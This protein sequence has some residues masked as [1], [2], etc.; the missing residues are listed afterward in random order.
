M[1]ED[2]ISQW[3][4]EL[5]HG[6]PEAARRIW[7]RYFPRL[8]R[9]TRD[10]LSPASRRAQDEEDLAL[11]AINAL[12][13][14]AVEG[15]FQQLSNRDDLWQI[16]VMIATRKAANV[17]RHQA[18]RRESGECDMR[19]EGGAAWSLDLLSD[20]PASHAFLNTI[21]IHCEELLSK[22]NGKLREVAILKLQ[23]YSNEEI[24]NLRQ[25]GLSTIER[26]LKMIREI[27]QDIDY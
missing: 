21:D 5:K 26:Y 27:W 18:V 12:C 24:G 4:A 7:D 17:H 10:K 8:C 1:S 19:P 25:R 3:I 16:M 9:F 6:D 2:S 23:G 20:S 11:S 14:G 13:S 15:R 22:L